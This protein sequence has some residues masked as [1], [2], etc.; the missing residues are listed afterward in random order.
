MLHIACQ[1]HTA[2]C[3]LLAAGQAG[4][5]LVVVQLS[6]LGS[7]CEGLSESQQLPWLQ[8]L[9]C[10]LSAQHALLLRFQK[11]QP[12]LKALFPAC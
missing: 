3:A 9:S 12:S 6:Q 2:F 10:F 5:A 11:T 1:L 7:A 8:T 4:P